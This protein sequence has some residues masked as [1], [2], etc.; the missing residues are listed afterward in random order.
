MRAAVLLSLAAAA[1]AASVCVVEDA[2]APGRARALPGACPPSTP[3][4]AWASYTPSRNTTGWDILDVA[5]NASVTDDAL[6]S[7]AAGVAEGYLTVDVSTLFAANTGATVANSKKLQK[8]L[9]DNLAWVDAQVAAAEPTDVYWH[10]VGAV[11][12]Q[13]R[14]LAAGHAAAGGPLTFQDVYNAII[15]GGDMFN[16]AGLYGLSDAQAARGTNAARAAKRRADH[17]SAL[18]RL[19]PNNADIAIAHTTWSG[20]ENMMRIIKRY[21][22]PMTGATGGAPVAGRFVALSGYPLLMQY[23]SDDFYVLSSGLVT[24]ETTIDNDNITLAREFASTEVV[25]EWLRNVVANRLARTGTEW[26]LLFSKFA[27]GTY[28]NS[29]MVVDLNLFTPSKPL[30]PETLLVVEEM[31][32]HVSV[33]DRTAELQEGFWPSY[34]VP[35]DP[36]IFNI[37]GQQL[38]VDENGGPTGPGAF[39]T[40]RNTSRRRIFD[41]HAPS[42]VDDASMKKMIRYN[43]WKTDPLATLG[44]GS[45]PPSSATN[46]IADRSDLNDKNGD[47]TIDDVGF[48]DSAAID[49]KVTLASWIRAAD[50]A[51]GELPFE[52][53]SGPTVTDS[54]PVFAWSTSKLEKKVDHVGQ[55]D[56]WDFEW[57]KEPW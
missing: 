15:Q 35:S 11:M 17:C 47:Y 39:F 34:N 22:L 46:A 24:L 44:C 9:D 14:G 7:Y 41:R 57:V 50:F 2:A 18:V 8:F 6:A 23:S 25:L 3:A 12:A 4:L 56:A 33:I 54:C 10:S 13:V 55:V 27:S 30:A 37:S 19:T 40:F 51:N 21:D 36:F 43:E 42:V 1:S 53:I 20:F 49:A 26:A 28:T 29:W 5:S 52:A 45:N 38:L 32:G 16:L 31:P 48:G